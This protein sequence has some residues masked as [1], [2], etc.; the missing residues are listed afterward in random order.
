M[1]AAL[2][3]LR[4]M[5]TSR[6]ISSHGVPRSRRSIDYATLYLM[7]LGE[8]AA[9]AFLNGTEDSLIGLPIEKCLDPAVEGTDFERTFHQRNLETILERRLFAPPV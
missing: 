1:A 4:S 7:R 9:S 8:H 5:R 2:H 6:V 3:R